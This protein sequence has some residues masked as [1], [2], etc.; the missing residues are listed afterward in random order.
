MRGRGFDVGDE[1][2]RKGL[3]AVR[4]EGRLEI[5]A[6]GPTVILD[7]AHNARRRRGAQAGPGRIRVPET[8][9]RA[10]D[11]GGQATGGG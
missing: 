2:V 4:W 9:P 3:A 6:E 1:A 5:V 8:D 7:G 10:G 11:P